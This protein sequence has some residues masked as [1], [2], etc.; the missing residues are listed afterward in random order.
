MAYYST[1]YILLSLMTT[2]KRRP[3]TIT[4][5]E[6]ERLVLRRTSVGAGMVASEFTIYFTNLP[7]LTLVT[8]SF[9]HSPRLSS[10]ILTRGLG[11]HELSPRH[12]D[13]VRT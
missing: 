10:I 2:S 13:T 3:L 7:S 12:S 8:S 6:K 9:P 11:F 1:P 4:R 5:I